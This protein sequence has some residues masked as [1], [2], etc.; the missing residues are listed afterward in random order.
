MLGAPGSISAKAHHEVRAHDSKQ[1]H[2]GATAVF[3]IEQFGWDRE[4]Q[5]LTALEQSRFQAHDV[6]KRCVGGGQLSNVASQIGRGCRRP[7]AA[8]QYESEQ[9]TPYHDRQR[10]YSSFENGASTNEFWEISQIN[11]RCALTS[12]LSTAVTRYASALARAASV[13]HG[14]ASRVFSA[15][16]R[17]A[18]Q[19]RVEEHLDRALAGDARPRS[20]A[21]T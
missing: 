2:R 18:I 5:A 16:V 21:R 7:S 14:H 4:R 17:A 10:A 19:V 13:A 20:R 8:A 3:G 6:R 9:T 1:R 11:R 15:E 12:P